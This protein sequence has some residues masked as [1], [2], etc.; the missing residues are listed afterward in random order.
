[1]ALTAEKIISKATHAG[2]HLY[3]SAGKLGFKQ[4]KGADFTAQLKQEIIKNKQVIIDYFMANEPTN[5]P[6]NAPITQVALTDNSAPMSFAQQRL[7]LL[8]QIDGGSQQYNMPAS[9]L[10][11]GS[12]NIQAIESAF[13]TIIQRHQTLRT[14]FIDVDDTHVQYIQEHRTFELI[15]HDFSQLASAIKN[16]EIHS[17]ESSFFLQPFDLA[18][19]LLLRACLIKLSDTEYSLLVSLH[20]IASDGWSMGLLVKEFSA[21][22]QAFVQGRASSLP[23]LEIQ[24]TDYAHWQRDWS[25]TPE[26]T[27]QLSYWEQQLK[28]GPVVHNLPLD[29]NRPAKQ[30]YAGKLYSSTINQLTTSALTDF[31]KNNNAT[32]F[33]SLYSVFALL[34]ARYSNEEDITIGS[35]IANREQAE[36]KSLIGF[37]VNNL[38][39]RSD[40]S[41]PI[42]F[43]ELLKS[44]KKMLLDAYKNQQIPFEHIVEQLKPERNLSHSPLFQIMIIFQNNELEP[45]ELPGVSLKYN[46]VEH[47]IAKYELTLNISESNEGLL[48]DWEYNT[49][50]FSENTIIRFAKHFASLMTALLAQPHRNVLDI[51]LISPQEHQQAVID[52]NT[53]HQG[54][55]DDSCIH[56]LIEQQAKLTPHHVAIAFDGVVLTYKELNEQANQLA[57]YL[58]LKKKVTVDT[59]VG[60]CVKRSPRMIIALLAILKSGA[61][62]LPLDS[63][64]PL[65]RLQYMIDDSEVKTLLTEQSVA[66]KLNFK[67]IDIVELDQQAIIDEINVQPRLNVVF[68]HAHLKTHKLAYVIY[69]SGSTGQPKGVMIEHQPLVNFIYSMQSTLSFHSQDVLLTVT[70]ISF[71]I[72]TLEI[73]LPLISGGTIVVATED[74]SSSP[75]DLATLIKEQK[76]TFM[77]ATPSTWSLL[78]A[79]GWQP[80]QTMKMLSG[81]EAISQHLKNSLLANGQGA[82]WNMYGPTETCVWSSLQQL[83]VDQD[84]TI[85][86]AI[87]N[88]SFY[89][90][91]KNNKLLPEGI[92]GELH[93]G[94][95]GLARGYLKQP[96]LTADKFINSPFYQKG[97]TTN[98]C[99]SERLYKTGDLVRRLPNGDL[100]ILGRIDHQVKIRGFRIELGEIEHH[101]SL[102]KQ[103]SDAIVIAQEKPEN[104]QL[105][106]Y[107]VTDKAKELCGDD[108]KTKQCRYDFIENIRHDLI[109]NLPDYMVPVSFVFLDEFPL[110][111][112]GKIDRIALSSLQSSTQQKAYKAPKNDIEKALCDIWQDVLALEHVGTDD[113]FFELGGHSLLAIQVI[114]KVGHKLHLKLNVTDV[115]THQSIGLLADRLKTA[116][117]SILP[118]L[119]KAKEKSAWPLSYAQKQFWLAE[120]VRGVSST[121]NMPVALELTGKVEAQLIEQVYRRLVKKHASFRTGFYTTSDGEPKQ[122]IYH[123]DD[124]DLSISIGNI[125]AT[126]VNQVIINHAE[127]VFDLAKPPLIR[128]AIFVV[129]SARHILLIN[130]HHIIS[131]GWS[132][133]VMMN[134]FTELYAAAKKN[135][136]SKLPNCEIEYTDYCIWQQNCFQPM[137]NPEREKM[138]DYWVNILAEAPRNL[139]LPV[140]YIDQKDSFKKIYQSSISLKESQALSA[141]SRK[142][143]GTLFSVLL[144]GLNVLL[145]KWTGDKDIVIGS[146]VSGRNDESLAH[147]IGCFINTIVLRSILRDDQTLADIYLE[148]STTV[149]NGLTNQELPIELLIEKLNPTR[150]GSKGLFNNVSLRLQNTPSRVFTIDGAAINVIEPEGLSAQTQLDLM[151]EAIETD[152]GLAINVEYDSHMFSAET[153]ALLTENYVDVLKALVANKECT[154]AD[155]QLSKPLLQQISRSQQLF[156]EFVIAAN[157]TA[158]PIKA[159]LQFW[160]EQGKQKVSVNFS[161]YSQ[162]IQQLLDL[163][164]DLLNVNLGRGIVLIRW[165]DWFGQNEDDL[166]ETGQTFISVLELALETCQS[167]LILMICPTESSEIFNS[168]R[169]QYSHYLEHQLQALSDKQEK[170]TVIATESVLEHFVIN[171]CFDNF[172]DGEAHIPYT[173]PVYSALATSLFRQYFSASQP[174]HKVIVLDCDNTLWKGVC[175]EVGALGV[176]ITAEFLTLQR[177]MIEQH[178]QGVLLC[179]NSKNNEQDVIDVFQ[180]HPDMLLSLDHI[181]AKKINWQAKSENL[182]EMACELNLGLDSFIFVDDDNVQCAEV[183]SRL[184]QVNTIQLPRVVSVI[185]QFIQQNWLFDLN[186]TKGMGAERSKFYQENQQRHQQQKEL[187]LAEFIDSLV[188]NI[189]FKR[190]T[191]DHVSRASELSLRT[192]Q[193]NLSTRRHSEEAINNRIHNGSHFDCVVHVSDRFGDYGDVG[194]VLSDLENDKIIITDFMLSCRSMGRGVE[195]AMLIQVAKFAQ[196]RGISS[197]ELLFSSSEKN[198]P[199]K[200]FLQSLVPAN[201]SENATSQEDI[202]NIATDDACRLVFQPLAPKGSTKKLTTTVS[203]Q[204][205]NR[206]INVIDFDHIALNLGEIDSIQRAVDD[207][208]Q[209]Q[210]TQKHET[211]VF[212]A[213]ETEVQQKICVIWQALLGLEQVGIHDNFFALGGNSLLATRLVSQLNQEFS[214]ALP[215][216]KIFSAQTV[217]LISDLIEAFYLVDSVS[218]VETTELSDTEME[219]TI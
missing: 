133:G 113:N 127:Q 168:Q 217:E 70:S 108:T 117:Q 181:V 154:L 194:L 20:H 141:L 39:L 76:I 107:I 120:Q 131:D 42:N 119:T 206:R 69:T 150:D 184:P 138:L 59:L 215:L 86:Q 2:I 81:G 52:I 54:F 64:Y 87:A 124:L 95:I 35:P 188:L 114:A 16:E 98:Y 139:S 219:L 208:A 66:A 65:S 97:E 190:L 155:V 92:A 157:F 49:D 32:M 164:S 137:N 128:L 89:I 151:F 142:N 172:M 4:M 106:A 24:Y 197:I 189:E 126:E 55:P 135:E 62:Y 100:T 213:P 218:V 40:F 175:G 78:I 29:A 170:L 144:T 179:L 13:T 207:F 193:F 21:L 73:F 74:D 123:V 82:L 58:V 5:L 180:Q 33:M 75:A 26:F 186:K 153:I 12:V 34:I 169:Q 204:Q 85:G 149:L 99:N 28:G 103:V 182:I 77:Q 79:D 105:V 47:Q 56:E 31:C 57:H 60:L 96:Q 51:E 130:M 27:E 199:A 216:G 101:L 67:D 38:V 116:E 90:L 177:F 185:P 48:L 102:Q 6:V 145:A 192:N 196:Q 129:D 198:Q 61:A 205:V 187:S 178:S 10:L 50:I 159:A 143:N 171:D 122:K 202:W 7:W 118:A 209:M 110:T 104:N 84:I 23:K 19:N 112:N 156:P 83:F 45:L 136:L 68:Y 115:F 93:I 162:V 8:D 173:L 161:P 15:I 183:R 88:T 160:G 167:S 195:H 121:Y 148:T 43:N 166:L 11:C 140:D 174:Q 94:G 72:H 37:F 163:Q 46:Q 165:Q 214:V 41:V 191:S 176:E 53:N 200:M 80:H 17:T 125:S 1:M 132:I 71:D 152:Q 111:P 210:I 201:I 203:H 22:Y 158:E 211:V 25:Q 63:H 109:H 134:E 146:V 147:I 9:M 212:V 3:I 14:V 91:D 44:S 30:G 18:N 36:V